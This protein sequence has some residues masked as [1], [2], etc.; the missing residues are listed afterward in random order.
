MLHGRGDNFQLTK[1][2]LKLRNKGLRDRTDLTDE[3]IEEAK[4]TGIEGLGGTDDTKTYIRKNM[5]VNSEKSL[6]KVDRR[7]AYPQL[8]EKGEVDE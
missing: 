6:V 3:E 7:K 1:T 5:P 2:F 8:G 4:T